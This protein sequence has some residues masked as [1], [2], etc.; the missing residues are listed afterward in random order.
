MG[1]KKI[2]SCNYTLPRTNEIFCS[3]E[4]EANGKENE[5]KTKSRNEIIPLK[6]QS[7]KKSKR[8]N[9]IKKDISLPIGR[10]QFITRMGLSALAVSLSDSMYNSVKS[11]SSSEKETMVANA[12]EKKENVAS[13]EY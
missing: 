5:D 13:P 7:G 9:R 11:F 12:T 6:F 4:K 1:T 2:S 10:S 3:V 8:F